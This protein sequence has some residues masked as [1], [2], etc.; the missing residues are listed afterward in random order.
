MARRKEPKRPQPNASQQTPPVHP[1]LQGL[2][3]WDEMAAKVKERREAQEFRIEELDEW[4]QCVN[5]L[6]GGENGRMF[7]KA[8]VQHS[9]LLR[10]KDVGAQQMIECRIMSA[11]YREWVRPFLTKEQRMDIE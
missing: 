11:F 7:L 5:L 4:K 1:M 2:G 8:M 3:K 10:S 9:G 6:A